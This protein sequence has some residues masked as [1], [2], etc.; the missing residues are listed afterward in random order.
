[1]NGLKLS[2]LLE[3]E[4]YLGEGQEQMP[5]LVLV[6][7]RDRIKDDELVLLPGRDRFR[8]VHQ[9]G[10]VSRHQ[11]AFK[12]ATELT[13][14]SPEILEGIWRISD[15][16]HGSNLYRPVTVDD[17]VR[18]RYVLRRHLPADCNRD[19]ETF[20]QAVYLVEL[21]PRYCDVIMRRWQEFSGKQAVLEA[22]GNILEEAARARLVV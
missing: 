13:P 22:D 14:R 16:Y 21:E 7:R 19:Y 6:I 4:Y 11:L 8:S 10:G 9:C 5:V 12:A 18:Y 17:L 15:Q 20:E 1:M 3:R 2:A